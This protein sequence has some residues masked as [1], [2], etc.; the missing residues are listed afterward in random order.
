MSGWAS[1]PLTVPAG[2]SGGARV[3]RGASHRQ[4]VRAARK[5]SSAALRICGQG[6]EPPLRVYVGWL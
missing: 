1:R 4:P 6:A 3:A 2:R 5:A